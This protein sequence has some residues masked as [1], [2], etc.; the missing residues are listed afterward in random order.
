M[1]CPFENIPECLLAYSDNPTHFHR[2]PT[3]ASATFSQLFQ[4]LADRWS[5]KRSYLTLGPVSPLNM[6]SGRYQAEGSGP[7]PA[8]AH[9]GPALPAPPNVTGRNLTAWSGPAD[10]GGG[11]GTRYS[12]GL[13][14][15]SCS[16]PDPGVTGRQ[17]RAPESCPFTSFEREHNR[18]I[19]PCGASTAEVVWSRM[20]ASLVQNKRREMGDKN[21][22]SGHFTAAFV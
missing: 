3:S 10:E 8:H 1:L 16:K 13:R 18:V 14:E 7:G 6:F 19:G 20:S 12:E 4:H 9:C 21:V 11:I 17:V 22:M 5:S 2:K 15:T